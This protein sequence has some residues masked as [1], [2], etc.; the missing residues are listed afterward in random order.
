LRG[1]RAAAAAALLAVALSAASAGTPGPRLGVD[2]P[3]FDFGNA[4]PVKTLQKEI[5]L[6]NYGDAELR[7]AKV[8]TSCGCTVVGSYATR[9]AP[10][11]RT[12]LRISF[13]TPEALG[14]TVQTVTV[15]TNDPERPKVEVKVK[16]TVVA[17]RRKR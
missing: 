14:P 3:G 2:P 6:H 15:E 10:G 1:G 4:R 16:A 5:V 12:A 17:A 8:S 7:V 9:L 13:T 11:A